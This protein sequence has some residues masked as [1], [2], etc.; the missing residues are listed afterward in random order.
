MSD[1]YTISLVSKVVDG[2]QMVA[3]ARFNDSDAPVV[4]GYLSYRDERGRNG[5]MPY[6][7]IEVSGSL[8]GLAVNPDAERLISAIKMDIYQQMDA[9]YS[10][11]GRSIR[12]RF[13]GDGDYVVVKNVGTADS[14]SYVQVPVRTREQKSICMSDFD[15]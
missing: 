5:V 1:K 10:A 12:V 9:L 11:D 3:S 7:D 14:P 15:R 13:S 2:R 8:L 6:L 4:F